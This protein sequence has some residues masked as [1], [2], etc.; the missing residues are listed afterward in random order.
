MNKDFVEK[1]YLVVTRVTDQIDND[2]LK[3]TYHNDYFDENV[4]IEDITEK[5]ELWYQNSA[6]IEIINILDLVWLKIKKYKD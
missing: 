5:L 4:T 1:R 3:V 6:S 2:H